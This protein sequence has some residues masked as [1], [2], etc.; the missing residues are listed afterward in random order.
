[1]QHALMQARAGD[2]LS[3]VAWRAGI[4]LERFMEDNTET[5]KDL[6]APL[7]GIQLLLC[8]PNP[9]KRMNFAHC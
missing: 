7:H 5:V 3:G 1:M 6:D 2:Y 8:S 4:P 9:G